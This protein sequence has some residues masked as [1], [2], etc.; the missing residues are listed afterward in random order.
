MLV[1][2]KLPGGWHGIDLLRDHSWI[3]PWQHTEVSELTDLLTF[4]Q[5]NALHWQ[6]VGRN[7]LTLSSSIRAKLDEISRHLEDG[8]GFVKLTGFPLERFSPDQLKLLW[9]IM[10]QHLGTPVFQDCHGQMMREIRD[11]GGDLGDRHG[12][13]LDDR[14]GNEFLSSKARTYSNG[15]LRYHTDRTDVVGLMTL[16]Q[17]ASGG[18]SKVASAIAVHNAILARR[19]DLLEVLYQPYYRSR[20]GEEHGGENVVYALPVFG[21]HDG[22]LTTH[23]SRTYIEAAQMQ[24]GTPQMTAEQ[25]AA[26]DLLVDVADEYCLSMRL[27]PG[28][29][30]F[31]NSHITYHARDEFSDDPASG[32][33]RNLIRV[34]LS[35]PN[36]RRL[37]DDHQILWRDVAAGAV[38]GGIAQEPVGPA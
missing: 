6:N 8:F 1:R 30:Q 23:Y 13:M 34:W 17:A 21:L 15:V 5:D 25:W 35:M 12:R 7:D 19:P 33:V 31:L 10:A 36:S 24:T 18:L 20:L 32:N 29:M 28:D 26:I 16:G 2:N 38:R 37:P 11:E 4:C 3:V 14:T 27:E 9:M 22:K